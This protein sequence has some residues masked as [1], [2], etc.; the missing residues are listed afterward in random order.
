MKE[1]TKKVRFTVEDAEITAGSLSFSP[2]FQLIIVYEEESSPK[3]SRGGF[4]VK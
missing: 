1:K 3:R 4:T 2:I